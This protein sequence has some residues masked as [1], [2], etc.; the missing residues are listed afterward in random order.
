MPAGCSGLL[1]GH[2]AFGQTAS[3]IECRQGLRQWLYR[4]WAGKLR[5]ELLDN[6]TAIRERC[7]VGLAQGES[8]R[9]QENSVDDWHFAI[10]AVEA[11][12]GRASLVIKESSKPLAELTKLQI[13]LGAHIE[14]KQ[15]LADKLPELAILQQL[16]QRHSSVLTARVVAEVSVNKERLPLHVLTLGPDDP[17]LPAV[18]FF[19]GV[20]GLERIGSQVVLAFLQHLLARMTWD[21]ALAQ[22]LERMRLVFMPLVNPGGMLLHRRSNPQGVDLMRN[23]PLDAYDRAA[24]L[25][26]G[27][28]MGGWLPWYRGAAGMP[29]QVESQALCDVVEQEL[30]G[31]P[32]AMA[33]DCHSGFGLQ[34]RI[35]F[36]LACSR[37][38][39]EVLGELFSLKTLLDETYP[40]H[41]YVFEPQSWHYLTHGDLWDHL[42][43]ESRRRSRQLFLP[44]TLE[45]G[46]WSWVRKNPRQLFSRLG[47]FNP[48]TPHRHARVMRRHLMLM[49]F[50]LHVADSHYLANASMQG[51]QKARW[52]AM[53]MW[54]RDA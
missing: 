44:L 43:L 16:M 45:M 46:S 27:H 49:D 34:D 39:I 9:N 4:H 31:R 17:S 20:H 42:Y 40:H 30:L 25:V 33:L 8:E 47:V 54:Y 36:P 19:G 14:M 35:W 22:L 24:W 18:G 28:R 37:R 15:V 50:L 52:D 3:G 1:L 13:F 53:H 51:C 29:M 10:I 21:R 12:F 23:A 48:V 38:P 2:E 32:L 6:Q 26:G 5:I 41:H 7:C 11:G